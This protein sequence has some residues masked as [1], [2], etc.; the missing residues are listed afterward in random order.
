MTENFNVRLESVK[1]IES[2]INITNVSSA[3]SKAKWTDFIDQK[4]MIDFAKN[5]IQPHENNC[6]IT[7]SQ[8]PANELT[9]LAI[10]ANH[11]MWK[12]LT[13]INVSMQELVINIKKPKSIF[14]ATVFTNFA[15]LASYKPDFLYALNTQHTEYAN[16]FYTDKISDI[17][18]ISHQELI[19]ND[20]VDN[21]D[22]SIVRFDY[23]SFDSL[24]LSSIINSTKNDGIIMIPGSSD[25]GDL[26]RMIGSYSE[27]IHH[28]LNDTCS[29]V[30]HLPVGTGLTIC[31]K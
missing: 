16:S 4:E 13:H 3:I 10:M 14:M 8:F 2:G 20:Y 6:G 28:L 15:A 12:S 27:N 31:V 22:L 23:I 11:S 21:F 5:V 29:T 18:V 30:L 26:Y 24:L 17:N 9:N 1:K 7:Y 19:N 25:Q